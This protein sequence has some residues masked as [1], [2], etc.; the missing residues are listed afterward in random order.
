[1]FILKEYIELT[2]QLLELMTLSGF[3]NHVTNKKVESAIEMY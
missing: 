1:M 3:I 2:V